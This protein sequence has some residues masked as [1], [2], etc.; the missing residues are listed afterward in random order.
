MPGWFDVHDLRDNT[1]VCPQDSSGLQETERCAC[2]SAILLVGKGQ[3]FQSG[4]GAVLACLQSRTW[5]RCGHVVSL[6]VRHCSTAFS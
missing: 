2:A 6:V 1:L 4:Q 3:V 5:R